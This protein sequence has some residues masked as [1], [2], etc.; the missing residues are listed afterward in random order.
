[1][2]DCQNPECLTPAIQSPCP[3][4]RK[5]STACGG[6]CFYCG[7]HMQEGVVV[8]EGATR[9]GSGREDT[10]TEEWST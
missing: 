5:N 3:P 1:M 9:P 8:D 10:H 7:W 2:A 4:C 6:W